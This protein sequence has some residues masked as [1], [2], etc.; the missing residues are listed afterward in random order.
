MKS[1]LAIV[2]VGKITQNQNGGASVYYSHLELLSKAGFKIELLT[3]SW[4]DNTPFNKDDYNEIAQFI[5]TLHHYAIKSV[6]SKKNLKRLYNAVFNPA[7]FEYF[8][9]SKINKSFLKAF[10]AENSIDFIWAEWRWAGIWARWTGLNVPVI[11]AHHDWEY[12]LALL[13]SKPN[14]SKYFHT[15]QKKRVEKQLVK[16]VTACV[17]GSFTETS[18]IAQ[19]SAKLALYLPI[20][21]DEI[22][23]K[24]KPRSTP[25]IVHLGGMGTTANRLGLERFLDV[26]WSQIKLETPRVKLIV[27]GGLEAAQPSLKEKLKD[28][29]ITCFG[30]VEQLDD[31]LYPNDIHIVPWEYNTG[32][33][34]RIPLVFN[35]EQVLVATKASVACY[36]ELK[37]DINCIL[38]ADLPDM[39]KQISDLYKDQNK[40]HKLAHQGKKTFKNY[41]T[42]ESQVNNLKQFLEDIL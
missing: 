23:P 29:N 35:Y 20:T 39:T 4:D 33:R 11:Y 34:T 24:L 16:G 15:F 8:F 7:A 31:N 42:V 18:E 6:R 19:I 17:S 2:N 21:Y 13:R 12:K 1:V 28:D 22:K 27:I 3:V 36:P 38:C 32:T 41:F 25:T 40:I 9:L 5:S 26:C 14:L 30:F 10:V 37:H